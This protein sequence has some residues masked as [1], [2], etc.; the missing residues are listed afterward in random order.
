M[1]TQSG[2]FSLNNTKLAIFDIFF[3]LGL[4]CLDYLSWTN[5]ILALWKAGLQLFF[6]VFLTMKFYLL[7]ATWYTKPVK[8]FDVII[9]KLATVVLCLN[10]SCFCSQMITDANE[11]I[12]EKGKFSIWGEKYF[13]NNSL[14]LL[15]ESNIDLL[16]LDKVRQNTRGLRDWETERRVT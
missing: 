5:T 2:Y 11:N 6:N 13:N 10:K 16:R 3:C 1:I 9:I 15:L 4:P 12:I 7:E 14:R 8:E